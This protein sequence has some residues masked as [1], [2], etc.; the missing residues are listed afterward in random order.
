MI[1][2]EFELILKK[3]NLHH[4]HIV[5]KSSDDAHKAARMIFN[6]GTILWTEEFILMCLDRKN[7]IIGVHKISS[8]GTSAVIVDPKVVFHLA[9]QNT[10][11]SIIVAHNH[12]SG[13][14]KASQQDIDMTKKL[15]RIGKDLEMPVLDHLILSDAGYISM[16]D[17]GLM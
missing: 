12:P 9:L 10:A 4:D 1:L 3:K 2:P 8:G 11:S 15:Q 17:E 13:N 5:V 7:E 16:S 6:D 14:L